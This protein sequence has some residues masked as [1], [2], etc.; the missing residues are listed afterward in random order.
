MYNIAD[1]HRVRAFAAPCAGQPHE[2]PSGSE[3]T[4]IVRRVCS[5]HVPGTNT[6]GLRWLPDTVDR[7]L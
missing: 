3:P 6:V 7:V 5:S 2:P 1:V 4:S